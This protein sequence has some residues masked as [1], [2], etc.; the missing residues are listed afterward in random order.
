[1]GTMRS[2]SVPGVA[3]RSGT[4]RIA[5]RA[6]SGGRWRNDHVGAFADVVFAITDWSPERRFLGPFRDLFSAE[7]DT[8]A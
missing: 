5:R 1:M 8:S 2:C 3:A 6:I 7:A 4:T